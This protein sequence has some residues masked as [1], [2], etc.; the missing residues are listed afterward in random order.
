MGHRYH[1]LCLLLIIRIL[2]KVLSVHVCNDFHHNYAL[3][4][5]TNTGSILKK[6]L[7]NF[8][9]VSGLVLLSVLSLL[10][11]NMCRSF[12][13]VIAIN[14]HFQNRTLL[15]KR[16]IRNVDFLFTSGCH[17]KDTTDLNEHGYTVFLLCFAFIFILIFF[18]IFF[19]NKID[20]LEFI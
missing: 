9:Y 14:P 15:S 8:L 2:C 19:S 7:S 18:T 5:A 12:V 10:V 4:Y 6:G 3:F 13:I 1:P 20:M 16:I 17:H 11:Y